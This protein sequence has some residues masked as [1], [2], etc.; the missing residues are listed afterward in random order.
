MTHY[1]KLIFLKLSLA[2]GAHRDVRKVQAWYHPCCE[3][4]L[5]PVSTHLSWRP[6]PRP[7]PTFAMLETRIVR[8]LWPPFSFPANQRRVDLQFQLS[9][10]PDGSAF[11][12]EVEE[13][14]NDSKFDQKN[15]IRAPMVRIFSWA[16][17]PCSDQIIFLKIHIAGSSRLEQA[18]ETGRKGGYFTHVC[19]FYNATR[20]KELI[21]ESRAWLTSGMYHWRSLSFY[22]SSSTYWQGPVLSQRQY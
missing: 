21:T 13:W 6:Q 22:S 12:K 10:C 4:V 7:S 14:S 19:P 15:K 8:V 17:L 1:S 20:G 3:P 11:W 9:V 16:D 5:S 18:Y 2:V